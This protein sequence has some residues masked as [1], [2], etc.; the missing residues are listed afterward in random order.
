MVVWNGSTGSR[1]D[2]TTNAWE[3]ISTADA[4]FTRGGHAAV[5]TGDSMLVWGGRSFDY[6][7][8][9]QDGGRY[10]VDLKCRAVDV[11]APRSDPGVSP[12]VEESL[13]DVDATGA[14]LSTAKRSRRKTASGS[15]RDALLRSR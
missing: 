15:G 10:V 14:P 7:L 12:A 11:G 4:P 8:E 6:R 2:P 13:P 9:S 3:T 5:W 1:Y